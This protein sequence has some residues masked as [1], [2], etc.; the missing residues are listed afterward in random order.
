MEALYTLIGVLFGSIITYLIFR[1]ERKDK[2]TQASK[3]RQD[4]FRL[5]AIEKRLE[6]H[7]RAL[8]LWYELKTVIHSP[9][10][11]QHKTEVLEAA[12]NF[13]YENSL[14][15]EKQTRHKFQDAFWIVSNYKMWLE[16]RREYDDPKEKEK[17]TKFYTDQWNEFHKLFEIIQKEVELEPIKP[18]EDKTPEGEVIKKDIKK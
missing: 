18:E 9:D 7:Q 13:W 8:K 11:D 1:T 16:M 10:G 2:L 6:A 14:Y 3:E 15:L 17:H 4:K 5:V 12:R